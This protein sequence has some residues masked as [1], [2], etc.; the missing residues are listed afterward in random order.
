MVVVL[1]AIDLAPIGASVGLAAVALHHGPRPRQGMVE[2]RDFVVKDI[3][4]GFVDIDPFLDD[5][6]I[7]LVQ[8]NAAGVV[9]ARTFEAASLDFEQ[10]VTAVPGSVAPK[11]DGIA[12][13]GRLNC[14]RP[15]PPIGENA[16]IVVDVLNQNMSGA[17]RHDEFDLAVAIGDARHARIEAGIGEVKALSR[18]RPDP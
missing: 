7:I 15:L 9:G 12:E 17:R 13:E 18:R 8:G 11:A 4:I 5:G 3:A 6:E 2:D 1:G 16:A 14:G 10:V